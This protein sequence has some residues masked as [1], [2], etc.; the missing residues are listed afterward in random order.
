MV[1]ACL[2]G[3]KTRYN[4]QDAYSEKAIE[5]LKNR[6][7]VPVCPEQL[8]GLPTP[9]PRA[10]IASGGGADILEGKSGV[11]DEFGAD[12]TA[13]FLKGAEEALKIARLTG[14]KEA[15]LKEKS[16][17]CGAGTICRDSVCVSGLGVTATLLKKEGLKLKGF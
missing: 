4:G 7:I 2:L 16:P 6:A 12:V 3:L 8:G 15:F 9:R 5:L 1:S 13:Y 17:S 10:E 14:A 11:I